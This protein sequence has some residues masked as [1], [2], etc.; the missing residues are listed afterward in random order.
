MMA[1]VC[2]RKGRVAKSWNLAGG[3]LG[4]GFLEFNVRNMERVE[5]LGKRGN[6]SIVGLWDPAEG[7]SLQALV[8]SR[9]CYYKR[10]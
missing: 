5:A 8:Q 9:D 4:K 2:P 7:K 10:V 6:L 1:D 3:Y